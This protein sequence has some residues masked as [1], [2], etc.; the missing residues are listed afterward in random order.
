MRESVRPRIIVA[1]ITGIPR[2]YLEWLGSNYQVFSSATMD[3]IVRL[4]VRVSLDSEVRVFCYH[5]QQCGEN[6]VV[7][8]ETNNGNNNENGSQKCS[9]SEWILFVWA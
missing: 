7:T 6:G 3:A 5:I 8:A 4:T 1:T 2:S 9:K